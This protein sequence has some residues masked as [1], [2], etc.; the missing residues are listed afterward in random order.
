[1]GEHNQTGTWAGSDNYD[2]VLID[3]TKEQVFKYPGIHREIT[4]KCLWDYD[5]YWMPD[6]DIQISP[7]GI[8]VM[9]WTMR[10]NGLDLVQPSILEAEDSYPS[11]DRFIHKDGENV[12]PTDF[13]EIMCPAFSKA[14]LKECIETF[15]KSMSGWGLDLV[16][17]KLLTEKGMKM[18]I[19]NDVIARHTRRVGGGGLYKALKA[20]GILPSHDRKRLMREY[21]I[22][23]HSILK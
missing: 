6:E 2:T 10:R 13:V 22:T 1:M 5:Y 7:R 16:W 18:A 9:F 4:S 8:L 19:I 17:S 11:W 20:K 3:Y 23:E 12:I 21:G 14:A 15:P